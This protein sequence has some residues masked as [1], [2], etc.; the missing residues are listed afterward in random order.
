MLDID[1]SREGVTP[2]EAATL[3]LFRDAPNGPEIFCVERHKASGF[4][5]GA[6]VFPGGKVDEPDRG[7]AWTSVARGEADAVAR[8]FKIAACREA[9]EE[10]AILPV[11]GGTLSS[12]EVVA[13]RARV[14][15]N[16]ETLAAFLAARGLV[17]DLSTLV[18]YARWVTPAA[19]SRRFDTRFYAVVA[20]AGQD[21][22]HDDHE[23]TSSFWARPADVLARFDRGEVQLMPP[24]HRSLEVFASARTAAEA[25]AIA[26]GA[27]KDPICPRVVPHVD[28]KGQT[29]ALTLPGDREHTVREA[30]VPGRSRFVLRGDR[31]LP[32]DAPAAVAPPAGR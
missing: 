7:A 30:R 11:A 31:W 15:K 17:L 3:L 4:L 22:H 1:L 21:G 18:Y 29:M 9:L 14:E 10:A 5:G 26:E 19:E 20:P 12:D 8:A 2:R 27:C 6:I 13:L 28:E 24:T 32:E 25:I 16:E 23:T